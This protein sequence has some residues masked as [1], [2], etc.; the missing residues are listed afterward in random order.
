VKPARTCRKAE[1]NNK[2]FKLVREI[3]EDKAYDLVV[4]GGGPTGSAAAICAA[5]LGAKTLLLEALAAWA[6]WEPPGW[7]CA[8]DPMASGETM[9]VGG[10]MREI[11]ET[12]YER[13]YISPTVTPDAW[14][15]DYHHWMSFSVEGRS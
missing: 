1:R 5:R 8:F 14:R 11:V 9:L 13:G 4:A 10:L 2:G 7:F 3:P 6:A 12:L 15:K